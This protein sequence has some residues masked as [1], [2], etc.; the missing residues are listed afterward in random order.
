M[1]LGMSRK[2]FIASDGAEIKYIDVGE[3]PALLYIYGMGSSITSAINLVNVLSAHHRVIVFD[4]RGYGDT[5]AAGDVG[6]H[7]SAKDGKALMEYLNISK[8]ILFGYS[9]GAAVVFS[10]VQQFGCDNL[11]KVIIGDMSPKLINED[12]WNL[13]LL[14]GHYTREMYEEDLNIIRSDY[15]RFSLYLTEQL[16]F[17]HEPGEDREPYSNAGEIEARILSKEHNPLIRQAL[18]T[19]MVELP[20]EK[21]KAVHSYWITMASADF[22]AML[23]EISVPTAIIYADPG[24]GYCPGTAEYIHSQVPDSILCPMHDCSHMAAS[25][26]APQFIKYLLDFTV[27]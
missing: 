11:E 12:G 23:K 24:S 9:M 22:R 25:E 7:Q 16:M 6:I 3:G 8:Y 14:Q 20:L 1:D 27:A 26:N 5:A 4:Q 2:T 21:Q 19:G 10:Y 15:R 17:K 13:G 18:Y